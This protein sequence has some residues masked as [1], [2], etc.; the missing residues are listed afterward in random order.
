MSKKKNDNPKTL[1]KSM[2]TVLSATIAATSVVS[3]LPSNIAHADE[4]SA[5][6]TVNAAATV[7]EMQGALAQADLALNLTGYDLLSATG[8]DIVAQKLIDFRTAN[9]NFTSAII[10]QQELNK[11]VVEQQNVELL[12]NAIHAVNTAASP[13]DLKTALEDPALGLILTTYN[14]LTFSGKLEAAQLLLAYSAAHGAFADQASIQNQFNIAVQAALDNEALTVAVK[15]VNEATDVAAI[16]I[17]LEDAYLGLVLIS[18]HNLS[19]PDQD[20]VAQQLIDFKGA[21]GAFS[22][23]AAIQT[24]LNALVAQRAQ[25]SA[26]AV[27]I[28]AVNDASSALATKLALEASDLALDLTEYYK[29]NAAHRLAVAQAVLNFKILSGPF[30]SQSVIQTTLSSIVAIE[31]VAQAVDVVNAAADANS[32]K[33]ALTASVLSLSLTTYNGLLTADKDAVAALVLANRGLGFT[34]QAAVQAALD[35]AIGT[36]APIAALNLAVDA[37]AAQSALEAT[38]LGL[39]LG[40]AYTVWTSA[41]QAAVA[42]ALVAN[43]PADGYVNQAAV[44]AAFNTGVTARTAVAMV[45]LAANTAAI[46]TALESSALGLDLTTNGYLTNWLSLDKGAVAAEV[47][48]ARPGTGFVDRDAV[49]AAFNSAIAARAPLATVNLANNNNDMQAALQNVTLNLDLGAFTS[50]KAADQNA[51]VA[52]VLGA[53]PGTGYV[54]QAA[55]QTSFD[56]A[57]A[58]RK[59]VAEVNIAADAA[60]MLA[61]LEESALGLNRGSTTSWLLTDKLKLA[62]AVLGALPANGYEDLLQIQLAFNTAITSVQPLAAVNEA[63][64]PASMEVALKSSQLGLLLLGYQSLPASNQTAAAT[65]VLASRPTGGYLDKASL[66]AALDVAVAIEQL[67]LAG[68]AA[69]MRVA[70]ENTTLNLTLG[71]FAGWGNADKDAVA[72]GVIAARGAGYLNKAAVQAALDSEINARMAVAA[73]NNAT[74]AEDMQTALES[75]LLGLT[76][77]A[78]TGWTPADQA[79]VAT[80]VHAA[81]PVGGFVSK[82][83]V[84]TAFNNAITARTSVSAVNIAANTSELKTALESNTLTLTLGDYAGWL[85]ADKSAVVEEVMLSRP[86]EG[87]AN[88]AAV[89]LAFSAAVSNRSYVGLVNSSGNTITMKIAL[90]NPALNLALG[91]FEN[92]TEADRDAVVDAVISEKPEDGYVNKA[93]VQTALDTALAARL[94]VA[95]VNVAAIAAAAQTALEDAT[96]G[97]TPG[98]YTGYADAD[99]LAVASEVIASRPINGYADKAA[100][101]TAFD[102]AVLQRG[103]V[104]SVNKASD[105]AGMKSAV[106]NLVLALNLTDYSTLLL[107]DKWLV[108]AHILEHRPD[109][110]F[111][112]KAAVQL[113][114][115]S[116]IDAEATMVAV[117]KAAT[118]AAM[119]TALENG[120]LGLSLGDYED[121]TTADKLAVATY[122]L[123]NRQTDGYADVAAVQTALN[124]GITARQPVAAVNIATTTAD[125][126]TA[127]EK[128][129]LGLTLGAYAGW[130][131]SD[132]AAVAEAVWLA[133]PVNGYVDQAAIQAAFNVALVN[134]GAVAEVNIAQNSTAL[135]EAL[136][137]LSLTLGVYENWLA[138]DQTAVA[139]AVLVARPDDGYMNKAAIQA[140][141]NTAVTGRTAVAAVNLA[142]NAVESQAAL[143]AVS[144]G[145]IQGS[146]ENWTSSDKAAVAAAVRTARP[147]DGFADKAAV[148]AAFDAAVLARTVVAAV[149]IAEDAAAMQAALDDEALD[150]TFGAYANWTAADKSAVAEAVLAVVP[151]T[152]FVNPAAVQAAFDTA[153]LGR[154]DVANVNIALTSATT[155]TALENAQLGLDL[156]VYNTLGNKDKLDVSSKVLASRPGSGFVSKSA[157]QT[158]LDEALDA[159]TLNRDLNALSI[160]FA[161]GD[162]ASHVIGNIELSAVGDEGSTITWTSNSP[163]IVGIVGTTGTITRPDYVT[164]DTTVTLTATLTYNGESKTKEFVIKVIKQPIN[165]TES[166]AT[167]K[168]ALNVGFGLGESAAGVTQNLTLPTTGV[169]GTTITWVSSNGA[170]VSGDGT[171]N[172]PAKT[173]NDV[174]VTLTATITKNGA[175]EI[176][177]FTVNVLKLTTFNDA[178][179]V[180]A[181]KASLNV[182]FGPGESAAGVTQ[183]LT[184]PTTGVNGTTITW[185]SSNG[186]AISV[187]GTIN[188]PA[189]TAN[190]V[191]VTLTATITKNGA[192]EIK[193]FTVNV[194]KLTTFNDAESVA[195]DKAS[196]NVDFGLGDTAAG[197]TQNLT[198]LTEGANGTTITWSSNNE[199]VIATNG[200]VNRP[201]KTASDEIVTLT[202]TITKNGVSQTKE[203]TVNVLKLTTFNDTE[204][205][206]T[207]TAALNVIFGQGDTAAGVTQNVELPIAGTNGTTISWSS[208]NTTVLANNG[209]V[210]RPAKTASDVNVTLTAT[211][212]K[213]DRQETKVFTVNVLKLTTFNDTESV[214]TDTAALNVVFGQGDTAAGVT[215]N[216]SLPTSGVNGT[217]ISWSSNAPTV[218]AANGT[219]TRP[220]KTASDVNVTLTATITKNGVSETKTFTVNVLKLTTFN[221]TESVATD[222]AA[223]NVVFGHGD[224]AAGVTQ[225]VSLPTAGVNGTVISWSS[226]APTVIANNGTVNRPAKTASDVN[227][228][229]TAT[230][231][232]NGVSQTK[233]FTVNVLKLTAFNDAESVAADKASLD[234]HFVQGDTAA[235][236]TENVLLQATGVNGTIISWSSSAPTVIAP[237]GTV[238][239]PAKTANDVNVTLTATITK[240]G[241]VQ[242]KE[243]TVNV[244]KLSA[245]NDTE[246]VEADKASLSVGFEEG[247][248]AAGVTQSLTLPTVGANG[249]TI[250]WSSN[251]TTVIAEDGT[252]TRPAKTASD[253]HVKLTA[254]ITKNGVSQTKEFTVNVLKLTAFNDVESVAKDKL[255][256]KV[257]FIQGDTAAGVTQN[258]S[259]PITGANGT[260]ISW[261]SNNEAVIAEDGTVIRPANTES[262]VIVTLTA[263]ITKGD[264]EETKEFTVN[265]LKLTAFN[266]E[267]SVEADKAALNIAYASGETSVNVTKNVT[268]PNEGVNGTTITWSSSNDAILKSDGTVTRPA[269]RVGDTTVT[270]TATIT[271]NGVSEQKTFDVTVLKNGQSAAPA[272]SSILIMNN[273]TGQKDFIQVSGLLAGDILNVYNSADELIGTATVASGTTFASLQ[274]A[275]LGVEAGSVKVSVTRGTLDESEKVTVNYAK[276]GTKPFVITGDKLVTT[277]GISATVTVTPTAGTAHIG[278]EVV[279]FQLMKG[280]EPISIVVLEKDIV[281]AE[282]LT[283]HFNVSGAGYTVKVFVVDSYSGSFTEVGNSLA[284]AIVLE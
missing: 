173:A 29:L 36:N 45:N 169:N 71:A 240:N 180:E 127:L 54:D 254:T 105:T 167:D 190:D 9:G 56:L 68:N 18:Y 265:V 260:T 191:N 138:A 10:I 63:I 259:L 159:G 91:V 200:T 250:T 209:T 245:F 233:E 272:A 30:T 145:L 225:N 168:A 283:A 215:Q 197:V 119:K 52:A 276:E 211:I 116:A 268:L 179:S 269:H 61:A 8:K 17:A 34:D 67:N 107:S 174:N 80:A 130:T 35:A 231:T 210:N 111:V 182:G 40:N 129:D 280:T 103:P 70:L 183:N 270:L 25:D 121:W 226:N 44:Q 196:L 175:Q 87:F 139:A 281:D 128:T 48:S 38:A 178:E 154:T 193:T 141:F 271:K 236:V 214:A 99:K 247:D 24:K 51:V 213:G 264:V 117:N 282:K 118:A 234:I 120:D 256:L 277:N 144:L 165:D 28:Q 60:A 223:L 199:T 222:T 47:L 219:V 253:V 39:N 136:E 284:S 96:L 229:L 262:N 148:Q 33:S 185:V 279:V 76:P 205:V 101:Q 66:Q 232:K 90:S 86:S 108:A 20:V 157:I 273:V 1:T 7:T 188:R 207:D 261:S 220:V 181:D 132:K 109:G 46:Q 79:A 4:A 41:D 224:T 266:D 147:T 6:A 126:L 189:K 62:T 135:Q 53:R 275:Q 32:I 81:R 171:V 93:A 43:R 22:N 194:L 110:G 134:R 235:G 58:S 203:F 11:V 57:H 21:N 73:V 92:W 59:Y 42:N 15:N 255:S 85:A 102:N 150:L 23:K 12:Q 217:V 125:A 162:T 88:K 156:S 202:A 155:K 166:V 153:V 204:S 244:L 50:W 72:N 252:I 228:T 161:A 122:V 239:R 216:V 69:T 177:T 98:A 158:A 227:V 74:N 94:P 184:L 151:A 186:A 212:K 206:A 124:N 82:A 192:Q 257:G 97:L 13:S 230:I 115:D 104:A 123:S 16:K 112:D 198:L 142:S 95:S 83:A 49:E 195:A 152:G 27:A 146:Y 84:Q 55:V 143:E 37:A 26:Y 274:I 248:T 246:S 249:T 19:L 218:I 89:Q 201:A 187:D 3:V 170:V 242:T 100:V 137:D 140:A 75:N 14:N 64:T 238:N 113:A 77:G 164:G 2:A 221:D 278:K 78:Y 237:N 160:Q 267:E 149:N 131:A 263:T 176:K 65:A 251:N 31:Q 172:R 163:S 241:V 114:L 133:I 208:S 258:V 243:F 106:E 5:V